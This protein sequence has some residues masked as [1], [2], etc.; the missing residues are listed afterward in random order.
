[1]KDCKKIH[2]LLSLYTESQLSVREKSLVEKH[3]AF[4]VTAR[5]EMEQL[6]HLRQ[7]LK[8]APEPKMPHDLHDKIMARVTGKVVPIPSRRTFWTYTPWAL[9]TAA[10]LAFMV[11]NQN[12][13]WMNQWK[14]STPRMSRD[15]TGALSRQTETAKAPSSV[16]SS[17]SSNAPVPKAKAPSTQNL[18]K[19]Q[20]IPM[21]ITANEAL[22][23]E[24]VEQK[25]PPARSFDQKLSLKQKKAESYRS[26]ATGKPSVENDLSPKDVLEK[27]STMAQAPPAA[28][29]MEGRPEM[30][31]AS[32]LQQATGMASGSDIAVKTSA[33]SPKPFT[34]TWNGNNGL[35]AL[36]QK[37][38]VTNLDTF[39]KDWNLFRPGEPLPTVDFTKQAVVLLMAGTKPTPGYSIQVSRLEEKADQLVI[40]YKVTVPPTDSVLAQI[41]TH[42]WSM[43]FIPKPTKP[44]V[45]QKE[46]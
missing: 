3:L 41:L 37:E 40:L 10:V 4:C 9:G 26:D 39:Q 24:S 36:E 32:N 13:D 23:R 6:S 5:R 33:A 8:N 38:L 11:L 27:K 28:Q 15:E 30:P 29:S 18:A 21:N 44:V 12:T 45:F 22:D 19:E 35:A 31:P 14:V 7:T 42:P 17:I 16:S 20:P 34:L 25:L 2:L 43:Q 1:M 46:E